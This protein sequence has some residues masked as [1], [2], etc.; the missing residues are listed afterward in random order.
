MTW[1]LVLSCLYSGSDRLFLK[2][3]RCSSVFCLGFPMLIVTSVLCFWN[4]S[5][6]PFI[7]GRW[8]VVHSWII[9]GFCMH[10]PVVILIIW[11]GYSLHLIN[12]SIWV[13]MLFNI[14]L[15]LRLCTTSCSSCLSTAF[16]CFIWFL[17]SLGSFLL[18]FYFW[19]NPCCLGNSWWI[20]SILC[21]VFGEGKWVKRRVMLDQVNREKENSQFNPNPRKEPAL[22]PQSA[23]LH[24]LFHHILVPQIIFSYVLPTLTI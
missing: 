19:V 3:C 23:P 6:L 21:V 16:L 5:L 15:F 18:W 10:W 7:S 13:Y 17:S 8:P 4:V 12:W 9:C 24:P 14:L 1:I 22:P 11:T 2:F 20:L